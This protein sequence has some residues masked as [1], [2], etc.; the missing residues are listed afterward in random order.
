MISMSNRK[1]LSLNYQQMCTSHLFF[2]AFIVN[3]ANH[4]TVRVFRIGKKEDGSPGNIAA[5]LDFPKVLH[6]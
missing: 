6:T 2:R 1:K 5:A 3:L 4:N